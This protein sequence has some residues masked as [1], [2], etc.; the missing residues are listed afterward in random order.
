[1]ALCTVSDVEQV[2]GVDLSTTDESTVTN[3]LIPTVEAAISNFLGYD[4]K[5]SAS[6]TEKFDGDRT[7]DLF[8]SRSPVVS[9]TSV[10]EDGTTLTEGNGDD[11]VLYANLGRLRKVGRERWSNAKLQN[12]TVVYSAGY[13][14]S[15]GTAEDVPK[16]MK[17]VCARASGKLIVSAL[18]LASQQS[19]GSVGTHSADSTNDSQFQLVRNEGIGDYQVTYESVL[20]QLGSDILQE[21]DKKILQKYK[22]QLFTSAG[23]LD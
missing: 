2:L 4:P 11:Y 17:Y 21:A 18:S 13:S 6:I 12:I 16:D 22:R 10:T 15:E 19:T 3:L 7:E 5:Y 14:D 8:L 9:V 1:M 23:I 20:D